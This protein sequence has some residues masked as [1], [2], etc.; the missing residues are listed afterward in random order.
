MSEENVAW[1]VLKGGEM[2]DLL[3]YLLSGRGIAAPSDGSKVKAPAP[4]GQPR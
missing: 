4:K 1:P 2:A 3:D